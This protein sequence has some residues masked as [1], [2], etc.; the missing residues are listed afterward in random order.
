MTE[1]MYGDESGLAACCTAPGQGQKSL[2]SVAGRPSM[3]L[4]SPGHIWAK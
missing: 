4:Q 2:K 3:L 1:L